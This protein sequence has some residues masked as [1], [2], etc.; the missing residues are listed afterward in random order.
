MFGKSPWRIVLQ[1][2]PTSERRHAQLVLSPRLLRASPRLNPYR[3]VQNGRRVSN[4]RRHV[5]SSRH[6]SNGGHGQ[7]S[8]PKNVM[9]TH[10][11]PT[12]RRFTRV[13][14]RPAKKVAKRVQGSSSITP[15]TCATHCSAAT[16][17]R[18][19]SLQAMPPAALWM[20]AAEPPWGTVPMR[21]STDNPR[22]NSTRMSCERIWRPCYLL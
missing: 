1:N 2:R 6:S 16:R 8:L 12:L 18:W 10:A 20:R 9:A 4:N 21:S 14:V 15:P 22:C 19:P 3:P 13:Y 17:A 11:R 5:S 7:E